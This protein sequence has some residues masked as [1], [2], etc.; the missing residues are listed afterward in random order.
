MYNGNITIE[1]SPFWYTNERL[2]SILSAPFLSVLTFELIL[3]TQKY[4]GKFKFYST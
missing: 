1:T 4:S 2:N 3:E